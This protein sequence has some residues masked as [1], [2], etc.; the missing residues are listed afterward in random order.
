M[1]HIYL[2]RKLYM[3]NHTTIQKIAFKTTSTIGKLVNEE[4]ETNPYKVGYTK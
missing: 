1:A 2:Y 3:K 4:L